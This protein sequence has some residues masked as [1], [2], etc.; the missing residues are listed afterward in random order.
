MKEQVTSFKIKLEL[1]GVIFEALEVKDGIDVVAI[2]IIGTN[3]PLIQVACVFDTN[4]RGA[5]LRCYSI[6]KVSDDKRW[7]ILEFIN[8]FNAENRWLKLL[9]DG[10]NEINC[11]ADIMF[12]IDTAAEQCF[13]M[14]IDL[15]NAV[16]D[17]YSELNKILLS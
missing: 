12:N 17:K 13:K 7:S 3:C 6:C 10:R 1:E 9:I 8:N 14:L 2:K 15:V 16:D 5:Q 4:D 11:E